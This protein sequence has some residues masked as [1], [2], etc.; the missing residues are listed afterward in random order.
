MIN[1]L[2]A[3]ADETRLRILSQLF[4]GE[5]CV[6]EIVQCLGLTQSNASRHLTVLKNAG[7]LD[8]CKKAQ[9]AY[10][11][12]NNSF[13]NENKEL[14]DYLVRKTKML[15]FYKNDSTNFEICKLQDICNK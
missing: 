3:A 8:S 1:I 4:K 15:P 11:K 10:F 7:I 9:W 13:I 6:C 5:M 12:I 14:Y 2:K